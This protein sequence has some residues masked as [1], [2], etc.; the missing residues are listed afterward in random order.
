M[1]HPTVTLKEKRVSE[2]R[3]RRGGKKDRDKRRNDRMNIAAS[4]KRANRNKKG[5]NKRPSDVTKS[6][7]SGSRCKLAFSCVEGQEFCLPESSSTWEERRDDGVAAYT[8]EEVARKRTKDDELKVVLYDSSRGMLLMMTP[9]KGVHYKFGSPEE[10]VIGSGFNH[11]CSGDW[12][13]GHKEAD[14]SDK[15]PSPQLTD[16]QRATAPIIVMLASYRDPLC[17]NTLKELFSHAKYPDRV[18]AGVVQQNDDGDP[19][20]LETCE[21]DEN[22]KRDRVQMMRVTLNLARGVMPARYRQ[23]LLIKDEHEFCLQIDSH[24]S[25]EDDWDM[26]AIEEWYSTENE[27]AVMST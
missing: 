18:Y 27:M 17:P 20:C 24:S 23:E 21:I 9:S 16:A 19:D 10:W 15:P 2:K 1:F 8:F 11:L 26:I 22:C 4:V 5:R 14:T 6:A 13:D 7:P 3:L 12:G 25:F